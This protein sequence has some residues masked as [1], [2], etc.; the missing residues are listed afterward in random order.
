MNLHKLFLTEN[1][2]YKAN[3]KIKVK[4]IMVH[5]TGANNPWLKRYVGPDDGLLGKN[6]Y[7]NHWNTYHPGGREVCVHAFIGKLAGGSIATY[8]TLPWDHRG[9]HA[10][11]AA[12]NTHIGFEI[13]EDGLTDYTYFQK[14]YREAVELCAY[15]CKEYG[16]TEQNIICHSEGYKQGVASNHGDVMHWFPKHGKSMDTFRAEVKALLAIGADATEEKPAEPTV[17]YPEKL[18]TGYYRVRTDWKDSKSQVGAYRI[19]ASAKNAADKN[20]GTFVFTNDG[21]AIYPVQGDSAAENAYRVHTVVKGDTLWDIAAL[22]L[23]KGSRYPEIKTLN[24][25]TSNV[26]YSGWKLKIPN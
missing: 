8:Q 1:A 17:T 4:G 18:T 11:G 26:I 22:Y 20:P 16:L 24:G 7:N 9:W 15:L 14:V 5:S 2:C 6:Q 21:V 10:G 23:G 13:C 25:L 19:L 12:N 3:R